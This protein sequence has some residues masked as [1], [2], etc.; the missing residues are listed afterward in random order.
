[1]LL[2]GEAGGGVCFDCVTLGLLR[3]SG[4]HSIYAGNVTVVT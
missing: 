4:L 3:C 1:M 2:V